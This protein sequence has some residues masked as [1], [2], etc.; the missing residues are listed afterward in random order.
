MRSKVL[1][2]VCLGLGGFVGAAIPVGGTSAGAAGAPYSVAIGTCEAQYNQNPTSDRFLSVVSTQAF[3][4]PASANGAPAGVEPYSENA[5]LRSHTADPSL[6]F[7]TGHGLA[8]SQRT[9]PPTVR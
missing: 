8:E 3:N 2:V 5:A 9:T 6:P 7:P 4:L 1:L